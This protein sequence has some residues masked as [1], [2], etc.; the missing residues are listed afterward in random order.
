MYLCMYIKSACMYVCMYAL[1]RVYVCVYV[2]YDKDNTYIH[3][4]CRVIIV[5]NEGNYLS[6]VISSDE[7]V[8]MVLIWL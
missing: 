1:I 7:R 2:C 3:A 8:I 6:I 4:L 5:I